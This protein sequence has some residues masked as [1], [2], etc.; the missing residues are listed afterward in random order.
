MTF[1]LPSALINL[2]TAEADIFIP[3]KMLTVKA[4]S[5]RVSHSHS[6][7]HGKALKALCRSTPSIAQAAWVSMDPSQRADSLLSPDRESTLGPH[8][9]GKLQTGLSH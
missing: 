8:Y 3:R 5:K 4:A 1:P 2:K 6:P 7:H 9:V